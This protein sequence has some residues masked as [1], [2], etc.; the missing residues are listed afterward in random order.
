M[1]RKLSNKLG[2][3]KCVDEKFLQ[4]LIQRFCVALIIFS[5]KLRYMSR[6]CD[7]DGFEFDR[8]ALHNYIL[9]ARALIRGVS[10]CVFS[11]SIL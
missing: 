8:D 10:L 3:W 6:E 1:L 5:F 7:R 2:R 9:K 11:K 4:D